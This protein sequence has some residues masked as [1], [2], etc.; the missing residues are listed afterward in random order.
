MLIFDKVS[1]R[2]SGQQLF[3]SVSFSLAPGETITLHGESGLG[4][5]TFLQAMIQ[6]ESEVELAGRIE[7][8][9]QSID[10][11][12]RLSDC[13][14]SVF[15]DPLLFPHL[16]VGANIAISIQTLSRSERNH[17]INQLLNQ[18]GLDGMKDQDPFQLS[19]GQMM[20][21]AVARALAPHPKVLLLDEPFSALDVETRESVKAVLFQQIKIDKAYAIL[22]THHAD[23]RP[24]GG[25]SL[26][27]TR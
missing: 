7:L 24:S 8:D 18:L 5:S 15:Q 1:V 25:A 12:I 3:Q 4:K 26:C 27:L 22:V 11:K 10:S 9:G 13:S 17:R 16:S 21:V 19:R 23:D 20:R 14:Q 6:G 2:R